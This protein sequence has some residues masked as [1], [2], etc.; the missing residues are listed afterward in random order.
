MSSPA[1]G[2]PVASIFFAS[3]ALAHIIRLIGHIHVTIGVLHVPMWVS[4]VALVVAG[5]LSIWLC[6]L[7]VRA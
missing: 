2:L 4:V 3:F 7:S 1:N 6:R 5:F